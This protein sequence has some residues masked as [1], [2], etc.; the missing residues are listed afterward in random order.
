MTVAL[1]SNQRG[2]PLDGCRQVLVAG[3]RGLLESCLYLSSYKS[4]THHAYHQ[5]C[6]PFDDGGT[7][8]TPA[9]CFLAIQYVPLV[10]VGQNQIDF[11]FWRDHHHPF[12]WCVMPTG[13]SE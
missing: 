3:K 8:T 10:L 7:I 6:L 5:V 9:Y 2:F 13:H 12:P 4:T 11:F 1:P